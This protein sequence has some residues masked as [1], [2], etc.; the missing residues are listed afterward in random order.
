[1]KFDLFGTRYE[2]TICSRQEIAEAV[3]KRFLKDVAARF[4]I[5][6][7]LLAI[8]ASDWASIRASQ[9]SVEAVVRQSYQVMTTQSPKHPE[10]LCNGRTGEGRSVFYGAATEK[11]IFGYETVGKLMFWNPQMEDGIIGYIL[12]DQDNNLELSLGDTL[13]V[14]RADSISLNVKVTAKNLEGLALEV[15]PLIRS[16]LEEIK[17][18]RETAP[19][20]CG[21]RQNAM[22]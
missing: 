4:A 13:Q 1:M 11:G 10:L 7:G 12:T 15:S 19:E 3:K 5:G 17:Q 9:N 14:N 6:L 16:T 8:G 2:I 21:Y 18:L 20:Q 22:Y